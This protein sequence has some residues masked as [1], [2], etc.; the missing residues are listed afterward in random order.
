MAR[1][2]LCTILL[3]TTYKIEKTSEIRGVSMKPMSIII[4]ICGVIYKGYVT[5]AAG[6]FVLLCQ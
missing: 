4:R 5:I 1:E 6:E 2:A 3:E